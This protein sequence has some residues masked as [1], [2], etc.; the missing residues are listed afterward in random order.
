MFG[1]DKLL[2]FAAVLNRLRCKDSIFQAIMQ[3]IGFFLIPLNTF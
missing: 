1:L 2:I 3:M